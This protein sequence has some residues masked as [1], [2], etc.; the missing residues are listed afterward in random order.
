MKTTVVLRVDASIKIQDI[1]RALAAI[2]LTLG[3]DET[4]ELRVSKR[5]IRA[6]PTLAVVEGK[7]QR[8]GPS[9]PNP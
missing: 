8:G 4:G 9:K 6:R 7:P 2:G 5:R 3:S 1:A